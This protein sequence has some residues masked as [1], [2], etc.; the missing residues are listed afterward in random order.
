MLHSPLPGRAQPLPDFL[1][2]DLTINRAAVM[3]WAHA[4]ARAARKRQLADEHRPVCGVYLKAESY[5]KIFA[6]KLR[7]RLS[8]ARQVQQ[9]EMG[10]GATLTMREINAIGRDRHTSTTWGA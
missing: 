10:I 6:D 9:L 1:S 2:P 5:A 7:E 3:R 4:R 8:F